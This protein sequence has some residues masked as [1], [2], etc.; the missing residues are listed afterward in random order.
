MDRNS[1]ITIGSRSRFSNG[2]FLLNLPIS[3]SSSNSR[4]LQV[5]NQD[6]CSIQCR[7]LSLNQAN[8]SSSHRKLSTA[9]QGGV[10]R[11]RLY[12]LAPPLQVC[13]RDT[14]TAVSTASNTATTI[15][16]TRMAQAKVCAKCRPGL[17]RPCEMRTRRVTVINQRRLCLAGCRLLKAT[18]TSL[19]RVVAIRL[20]D[21]A[22]WAAADSGQRRVQDPLTLGLEA[23]RYLNALLM[24]T[25]ARQTHLSGRN[26]P[27]HRS[28]HR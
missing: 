2:P 1:T 26:R 20:P 17:C 8:I 16:R 5:S 6:Q 12:H 3:I 7:C 18:A 14:V 4:I 11:K 10:R 25:R 19:G 22:I 15:C 28:R 23:E 24:T 9:H 21:K 13:S 27:R